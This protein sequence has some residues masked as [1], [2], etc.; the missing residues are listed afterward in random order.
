[1]LGWLLEFL[2]LTGLPLAGYASIDLI[3][4]KHSSSRHSLFDRK[5]LFESLFVATGV[6]LSNF[7]RQSLRKALEIAPDRLTIF[8]GEPIDPVYRHGRTILRREVTGIRETR[9]FSIFGPRPY[10]LVVR[11]GPSFFGTRKRLFI[12]NGIPDYD[13]LKAQLLAWR[14]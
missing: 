10:G 6:T 1:M 8:D 11:Y 12:P 9:M 7:L 2:M 3:F 4:A 14:P 13:Q 5:Y